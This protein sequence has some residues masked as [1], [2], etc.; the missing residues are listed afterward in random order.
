DRTVYHADDTVD[1]DDLSISAQAR[2][3]PDLDRMLDELTRRSTRPVKGLLDVGCGMGALTRRIADRLGIEDL[4][5]VDCD[6][7]R[8]WVANLR[9]IETYIVD[10]EMDKIPLDSGS[11]GLVTCFGVLP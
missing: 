3:L 2:A 8:L 9:A 5:G 1:D 6:D 10:H 7:E 4:F 11:V